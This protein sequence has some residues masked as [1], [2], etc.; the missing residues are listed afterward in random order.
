MPIRST[1]WHCQACSGQIG[2]AAL[3]PR[4]TWTLT[5]FL[6]TELAFWVTCDLRHKS[7]YTHP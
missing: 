3:R 6:L 2:P 1:D 4:R 7:L 5:R